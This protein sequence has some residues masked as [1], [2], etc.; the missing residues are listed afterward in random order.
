MSD[1]TNRYH[2]AEYAIVREA[3]WEFTL[4]KF[5]KREGAKGFPSRLAASEAP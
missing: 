2:G 3:N 5:A 4:E 1:M